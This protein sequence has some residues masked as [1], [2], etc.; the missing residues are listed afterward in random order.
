[1]P[2]F[3]TLNTLSFLCKRTVPMITTMEPC[4]VSEASEIE[5]RPRYRMV[6][7]HSTSLLVILHKTCTRCDKFTEV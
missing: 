2:P 1:M 6:A 4:A 3:L 5:P 7:L